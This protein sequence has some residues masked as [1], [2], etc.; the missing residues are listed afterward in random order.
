MNA[1]AKILTYELHDVLRSK[2][3]MAYAL[4]FLLLTESLLQF[5]GHSASALL[6]LMN[7]VLMLL[8]LVSLVFGTMYLYHARDFVELLLAQPVRRNHLFGG[9]YLGLA[10]PLATGFLAGTCLPFLWHGV[11]AAAHAQTLVVLALAG[12]ALTFVFVAL[13]FF[14]AVRF[15]DK[16]HG[17][18]VALVLWLF[19]AV[20]YDGL[21][22]LALHAFA[23]YPLETPAL[24]LTLLNPVDLARVLLLLNVD[25]S[26]LMG[27][28]GA[29][30]EA[31]FGS[32][33]GAVA[34][35]GA[36]LVW[37][38]VPLYFGLRRFQRKD[39]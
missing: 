34:A 35:G 28:T 9:L 20:L 33:W 6:S 37:L 10:V 3:V 16:A 38:V 13:A 8:P 11:D 21:V 14:I 15:E 22:L 2:W 1:T 12:V 29:V 39:F 25:I 36:L 17:L 19:L 23:D 5:G 24:V 30:F 7:V 31:F 32:T 18:G 27:Y 4:F 26:A